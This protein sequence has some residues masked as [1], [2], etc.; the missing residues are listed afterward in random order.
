M[1]LPLE[2]QSL[3]TCPCCFLPKHVT[4][5]LFFL[6]LCFPYFL[7]REELLLPHPHSS[8]FSG[9]GHKYHGFCCGKKHRPIGTV[10]LELSIERELASIILVLAETQGQEDWETLW[11]KTGRP[12]CALSW[13]WGLGKLEVGPVVGC[14]MW[15]VRGAYLAFLAGPK[16]EAGAKSGQLS[17]INKVLAIWD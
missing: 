8:L 15:L 13:G 17:V 1:G 7:F 14:P 16:L 10:Y 9:F 3:V 6:W 2:E 11:W 12:R 5:I 4:P